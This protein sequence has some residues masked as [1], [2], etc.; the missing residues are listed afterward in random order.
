MVLVSWQD[1]EQP[2]LEKCT[3]RLLPAQHR[4]AQAAHELSYASCFV[5][6]KPLGTCKGQGGDIVVDYSMRRG[7]T[8]TSERCTC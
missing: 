8:H 1:A 7:M 5:V 4:Q 6:R 3:D 2:Q